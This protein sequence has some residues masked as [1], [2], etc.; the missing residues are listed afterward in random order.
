ML[1][2]FYVVWNSFNVLR[3][4][5]ILSNIKKYICILYSSV[6]NNGYMQQTCQMK[7]KETDYGIYLATRFKNGCIAVVLD[8]LVEPLQL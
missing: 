4:Q 2:W 1:I 3:R 5:Q 6:R 8:L 7:N